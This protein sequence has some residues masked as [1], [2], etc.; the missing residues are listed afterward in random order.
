M[1]DP[2]NHDMLGSEYL[3]WILLLLLVENCILIHFLLAINST[4][5]TVF[6][7]AAGVKPSEMHCSVHSNMVYTIADKV[8]FFCHSPDPMPFCA[9]LA[10]SEA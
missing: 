7:M 6:A 5:N 9:L 1:C 4:N 8:P 3:L 2:T 10:E